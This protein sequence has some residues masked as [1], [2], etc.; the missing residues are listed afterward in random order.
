MDAVTSQAIK[1]YFNLLEKT[2]EEASPTAFQFLCTALA[3]DTVD[4]W[5]LSNETRRVLLPKKSK[6]M[7]YLPFITR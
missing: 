1:H 3:I 2:L 7:L 4:G 6:V 5:G